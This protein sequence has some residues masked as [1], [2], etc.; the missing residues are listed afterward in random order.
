MRWFLQ[1][2]LLWYRSRSDERVAQERDNLIAVPSPIGSSA[3]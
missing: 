3:D 1:T 2:L